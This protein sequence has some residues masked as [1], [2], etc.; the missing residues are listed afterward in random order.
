MKYGFVYI[1]YDRKHKRYYIG[2]HWGQ[3]DDGYIC[4]S[5]W[6]KRSYMRR[7][8]D[9]KRKIISR[10]DDRSKLIEEEQR[11]L[12][13]TKKEE[14][15]KRYYNL[16]NVVIKHWHTN[17]LQLLSVSQKISRANKGKH[18]SP[19]TEFKKGQRRSPGTEFK[20]GQ[21]AHNKGCTLDERYGVEKANEI[22]AKYRKAKL[23]KPSKSHTK[24][25]KGNIPWNAK[26]DDKSNSKGLL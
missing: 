23:G 26:Y 6:M 9:F 13:F 8:R 10:V 21:I 14:L 11:W 1:W 5:S 2:S 24:F 7:P 22:R 25:Q 4:S 18:Y 3:E 12:F 16:N 19:N 17:E 15:G 20:K